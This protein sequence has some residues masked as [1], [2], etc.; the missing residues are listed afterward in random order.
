MKAFGQM[1]YLGD[2]CIRLLAME[3]KPHSPHSWA[4]QFGKNS[5]LSQ[6]YIAVAGTKN[7]P[8]LSHTPKKEKIDHLRAS[9]VEAWLGTAY[10]SGG[11]EAVKAYWER[12]IKLWVKS[13]ELAVEK[14][15]SDLI[16]IAAKA[17][18]VV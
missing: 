17:G 13:Q 12:L 15:K 7:P 14:H 3:Y 2:T 11:I 4:M 9:H 1:D 8:A 6:V 5:F 18:V 10:E 16:H